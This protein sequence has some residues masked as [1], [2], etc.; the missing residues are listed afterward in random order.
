LA[1]GML[2]RL[3]RV[4]DP[5]EELYSKYLYCLNNPIVYIDPDGRV[6][7][8][9]GKEEETLWN[10]FVSFIN[11][12]LENAYNTILYYNTKIDQSEWYITKLYYKIGL[13]ISGAQQD[14]NNFMPVSEEIYELDQ[15]EMVYMVRMGNRIVAPLDKSAGGSTTF[16]I[17]SEEIDINVGSSSIFSN[18][19]ILSHEMKHGYQYHIGNLNFNASGLKGSIF[20]D[21]TDEMEAFNR[22]NLFS[23]GTS[24]SQTVDPCHW[25]Y[26]YY[27][28]RQTGPKSFNL[29]TDIEK[30]QYLIQ[31]T[32]GKFR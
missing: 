5:A 6:I 23:L 15:D 1:A 24:S 17:Y 27:K 22:Q 4:V 26:K 18:L 20:Y 11:N 25:V 13:S 30:K 12:K 28:G 10:N 21:K 14:L 32:Q 19:Q 16:N 31:K 29:L 8:T 9:A 3:R 7:E 2:A